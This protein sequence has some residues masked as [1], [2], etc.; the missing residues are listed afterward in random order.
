MLPIEGGKFLLNDAS[1]A[2]LTGRTLEF[3]E[4]TPIYRELT[5]QSN[6]L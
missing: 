3:S 1:S 4:I 5:I 2:D 6:V